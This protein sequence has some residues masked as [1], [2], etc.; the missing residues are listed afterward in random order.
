MS[1]A[2]LNQGT[3]LI[4]SG[5]RKDTAIISCP[6]IPQKIEVND[7][8]SLKILNGAEVYWTEI[9]RHYSPAKKGGR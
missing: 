6:Y 5:F 7:T 4:Q 8:L 1:Y 9:R 2:N 3:Y